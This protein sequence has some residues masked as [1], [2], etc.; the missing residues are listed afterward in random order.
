MKNLS[1]LFFATLMAFTLNTMG[2]ENTVTLPD[3][4]EVPG[5]VSIP[6]A[7]NFSAYPVQGFDI[8][9][10]YLDS[11]LQFINA[12]DIESAFSGMSVTNTGGNSPI[13]LAWAGSATSTFSGDLVVLNF[14][15][16]GTGG[17]TD[18]VLTQTDTYSPGDP[19]PSED[20]PSW[21]I[22][23]DSNVVTATFT[24]GSITYVSP[25][26]LSIWAVLLGIFLIATFAVTRFYRIV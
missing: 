11:D 26:P 10:T 19:N 9:I 7:V 16:T 20:F 6:V 5:P 13:V 23:A 21:L 15:Y 24:N 8:E 17:V 22:D 3:V 1:A 25:V 12:T 4:F 14:T 2:Q 18:L